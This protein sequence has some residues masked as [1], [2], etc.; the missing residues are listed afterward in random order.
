MKKVT[1]LEPVAAHTVT[2]RRGPRRVGVAEA[3][4]KLSEALRS[5]DEGPIVI[6]SRGR[7]VGVL[8]D[9]QTYEQLA[10]GHDPSSIARPGGAAFLF[11]VEELRERYGGGAE[12]FAP[13]PAR[14]RPQNPFGGR[15]RE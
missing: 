10:A 11:R 5:L 1:Q 9:V 4:A 12:N 6:H 7:D 3:K 13:E 8:M 14:V 2:A 15:R